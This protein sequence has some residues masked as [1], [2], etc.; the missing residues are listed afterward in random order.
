[1]TVATNQGG[2]GK[3]LLT[4][5][6]YTE[7]AINRLRMLSSR[8]GNSLVGIKGEGELVEM[9]PGILTRPMVTLETPTK[10]ISVFSTSHFPSLTVV[11]AIGSSIVL[12]SRDGEVV[13]LDQSDTRFGLS[14]TTLYVGDCMRN[15]V[16]QATKSWINLVSASGNAV[17]RIPNGERVV[18]CSS[19][20]GSNRIVVGLGDG[21][22]RGKGRV[23]VLEV[24]PDGQIREVARKDVVQ[25]ILD[26]AMLTETSF[27]VI[28]VDNT[29]YKMSLSMDTTLKT[30]AHINMNVPLRSI[31]AFSSGECLVSST[32]GI[33]AKF[34]SDFSVHSSRR[35]SRESLT[36]SEPTRVDNRE[37]VIA[38]SSSKSVLICSDMEL[39][40]ITFTHPISSVSFS[41]SH[42]FSVSGS[43]VV[44]SSRPSLPEH[45]SRQY[46]ESLI[47]SMACQL[48]DIL[49]PDPKRQIFFVP[50]SLDSP[51]VLN[52][53]SS[54]CSS[55]FSLA[56]VD[57]AICVSSNGIL[58]YG[59]QTL[60]LIEL[61]ESASFRTVWSVPCIKE[62]QSLCHVSDSM[63][64]I[65][66]TGGTVSIYSL[67]WDAVPRLLTEGVV[68][69]TVGELK[70][71][72]PKKYNRIFAI[73][74]QNGEMYS[75]IYKDHDKSLLFTSVP[76]PGHSDTPVRCCELLD[77]NIVAI[78]TEDA[79]LRLVSVPTSVRL[80][81]KSEMSLLLPGGPPELCFAVNTVVAETHAPVSAMAAGADGHLY[82]ATP[83]RELGVIVR[84]LSASNSNMINIDSEVHDTLI[85]HRMKRNWEWV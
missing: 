24:S 48:T 19:R 60:S 35:I 42:I 29:V 21:D 4:T 51:V 26:V 58:T 49:Q 12:E 20:S 17:F 11:S 46:S 13:E 55:L 73:N 22:L 82:F 28:T 23:L 47:A 69:N 67:S 9:H 66:S 57:I 2:S 68:P 41:A 40:R 77:E 54:E 1:M 50:T 33:V 43:D 84:S 7:A 63:F 39:I 59:S 8:N 34:T 83:D 81:E 25:E 78:A 44:V 32:T 56:P 76:S 5:Q 52:S 74:M 36:L 62:V 65:A 79:C 64:V 85:Q 14:E 16:V 38:V 3:F 27:G 61:T 30:S 53:E 70:V 75:L 18:S 10:A 72:S 6:E 71:F 80:D 37:L 15:V 45:A 31:V